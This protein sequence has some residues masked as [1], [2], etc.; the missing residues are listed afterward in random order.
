MALTKSQIF[1][2]AHATTRMKNIAHFG[3]Y[4]KAFAHVLRQCYADRL[5]YGWS[6]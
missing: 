6:V 2:H 3:S 5:V 4:Q 1:A